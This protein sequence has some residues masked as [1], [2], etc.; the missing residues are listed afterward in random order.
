MRKQII[1]LMAG[2]CLAAGSATAA[3]IN[4]KMTTFT[5]EGST[6]WKIYPARFVQKVALVTDGQV[7]IKPYAAGVLGGVFEGHK[8]VLDKRADTAYHFPLYEFKQNPAVVFIGDMPGG[9]GQQGKLMWLKAGGGYELWKEFR[10]SMGLSGL[11]CGIT[12]TETFAHSHKRVQSLADFKG[13][14]YRTLGASGVVMKQLG[15]SPSLV[16]GPEVYT[17]LERKGIDGA[18]YLDPYGNY[19]LG[20]QKIVKYIIIP[21]IHAPGGVYEVPFRN[22]TWDA[23]PKSIQEKLE[24]VCESMVLNA[25]A[26]QNYNNAVTMQKLRDAGKNEIVKLDDEVIKAVRRLGRE[27]AEDTA[28][29]ETAKGNPWM[30]KFAKSYFAFQDL[31]SRN[32]DYQVTD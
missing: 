30:A 12:G 4:L 15:A 27:W 17:M 23:M 20:F 7:K 19:A 18:E 14:R 16:P 24:V 3:E 21:G 5:G 8:A 6:E 32:S 22:E 1:A 25:Y 26:T 2:L 31:W 11:F 10:R 28:K 13:F 29:S 9:M